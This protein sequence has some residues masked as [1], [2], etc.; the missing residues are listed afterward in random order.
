[1]FAEAQRR[2]HPQSGAEWMECGGAYAVFNGIESPVTQTFGLGIF[3]DLSAATLR[4]IEF[5]FVQRRAPVLHEVSPF[6]GVAALAMLCERGYRPME[7]CNVMYRSVED[8]SRPELAGIRTRVATPEDR[9]LWS[10]V[11]AQGWLQENPELREFF[12]VNG[13]ISSACVGSVRFLA[14][15]DGLPGAAGTLCIHE[16]VALFGGAAT[17]PEMR[18]RGLQAA[19]I[20]ARMQY[21]FDQ[22]CDLLMLV[23]EAGSNS[24]RNAERN[25]FRVAYTR[26][27]WKLTEPWGQGFG[28]A[29]ELPPGTL[30]TAD[31]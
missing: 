14:E 7:I 20:Q 13:G 16:G 10:E 11:L 6:A 24:Q 4:A 15:L 18:R 23:A 9:D 26:T 19:L 29:A 21:A 17:V 25:G 2:L 30:A 3:E 8:P 5:F 28:P 27:K 22:G 1:M 12:L 31:S